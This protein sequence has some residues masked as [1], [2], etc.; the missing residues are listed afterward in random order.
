[1]TNPASTTLRPWLSTRQAANIIGVDTAF[2]RGEIRDG[3][4]RAY[5]I[6]RP[7]MRAVYRVRRSDFE[8]YLRTHWK[9]AG[10]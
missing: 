9:R 10:S 8:V 2:I 4:L 3:R 1:M 5:V 6:R 7:N